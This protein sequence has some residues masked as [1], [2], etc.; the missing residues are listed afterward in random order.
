MHGETIK[1][2]ASL[3]SQGPATAPCPET[4]QSISL[5]P[6]SEVICFYFTVCTVSGVR[7]TGVKNSCIFFKNL[8]IAL[9]LRRG[10]TLLQE[11]WHF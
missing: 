10:E 1:K 6:K 9:F 11:M 8:M 3:C 2:I 5:L 7:A 4:E